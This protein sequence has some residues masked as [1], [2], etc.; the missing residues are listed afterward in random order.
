MAL[1]D[2]DKRPVAPRKRLLEYVV[3]VAGRLVSV[4]D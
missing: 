3:K 1:E 4:D 2:F